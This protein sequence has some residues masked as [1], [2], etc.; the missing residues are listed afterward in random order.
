[1]GWRREVLADARAPVGSVDADGCVKVTSYTSVHPSLAGLDGEAYTDAL[2][3]LVLGRPVS[4]QE[5][6]A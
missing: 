6:V 4:K 2:V 3:E 1:M 5:D